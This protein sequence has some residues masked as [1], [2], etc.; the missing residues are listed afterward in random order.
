MPTTLK[1]QAPKPQTK[2]FPPLV[3]LGARSHSHP[4]PDAVIRNKDS[5]H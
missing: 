1:T 2:E 4:Y 5:K 3:I